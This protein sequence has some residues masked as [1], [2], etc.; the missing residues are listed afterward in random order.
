MSGS[1]A[2]AA[3]AGAPPNGKVVLGTLILVAAVANL[4]LSVA[5]VALPSIGASFD[6]SQT[7]LDLVAVGYSLG[8]GGIRPL[9]RGPRRP[10]RTQAD[11]HPGH[12]SSRS[13]PRIVA[14]FAPSTEI[15]FVARVAGGLAA[16]MAYPTTLALITALWSGPARTRS[17]AMWSALGGGVAM[18]GP[19]ISGLPAAVLRVGLRLPHHPAPRRPGPL[20]GLTHVPAHVNESTDRVDNL[21]GILSAIMIGALIVGPQ[22]HHGAQP[23]GAR[24]RALRHRGVG[25]RPVHR[26]PAARR[27]PALRPQDRR[28]TAPSGWRP[29]PASSSS[30]RSWAWPSSTSSTSRTCSATTRCRLARP[31]CR[32]SSSWC[33]WRRARRSWSR[34]AARGP[35]CSSARPSSASPSLGMLLLW[36]EGTPYLV[37]AIP[38]AL[39]GMGVGP[40]RHAIVELA[41]RLGA[42]SPG[43]HGVG[44]RRPPARP[45]WR[46]D[47]VHL[48]GPA[49]GRI[50]GRHGDR[51]HSVGTG[52]DSDDPERAPGVLCQRGGPGRAVPAVRRPDHQPRPSHPSW[53][54][55]SWRT[56]PAWGRCSSASG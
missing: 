26:P 46:L 39:M 44:H 49:H 35:R 48:R 51:H 41:D 20:H 18:L 38:L 14:A 40:R 8:S 45:G 37:V 36:G 7:A 1:R 4:N 9:V 55:T 47:D 50:R 13:R 24:H 5:N 42:G 56:S 17:I 2:A 21:G 10:L 32:R 22:L 31:S 19:L 11:D 3:S 12:G 25:A 30:A 23:P 28:P 53:T 43:G 6:A 33:S 16:G 34:I 27:E 54:A 29:S 52:R 15:L